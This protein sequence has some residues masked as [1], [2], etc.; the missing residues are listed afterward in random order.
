MSL[1]FLSLNKGP[2]ISNVIRLMT[3]W[4]WLK[5]PSLQLVAQVLQESQE[6]LLDQLW[7]IVDGGPVKQGHIFFVRLSHVVSCFHQLLAAFQD[8]KPDRSHNRK[9]RLLH[10]HWVTVSVWEERFGGLAGG[11]AAPQDSFLTLNAHHLICLS[12]Q[13]SDQIL[14]IF[15]AS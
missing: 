15:T 2:M 11:R 3:L 10:S 4:F 13:W 5:P 14:V 6:I 8:T 9:Q 12:F 1:H 7:A